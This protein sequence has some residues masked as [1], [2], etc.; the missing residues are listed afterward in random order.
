MVGCMLFAQCVSTQNKVEAQNVSQMTSKELKAAARVQKEKE[1]AVKK[2]YKAQERAQKAAENVVK[3][4]EKARTAQEKAKKA[5][6]KAERLT[7]KP[8]PPAPKW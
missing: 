6:E 2:A 3:A 1:T 5:Q 4:Q 8:L 7:G